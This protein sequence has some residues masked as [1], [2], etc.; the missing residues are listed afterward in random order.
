[1][2]PSRIVIFI[3]RDRAVAA[4]PCCVTKTAV[5]PIFTSAALLNYRITGENLV[6]EGVSVASD[7]L[8]RTPNLSNYYRRE[9]ELIRRLKEQLAARLIRVLERVS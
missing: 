2:R 7:Y 9:E 1:M 6:K 3:F 5:A 4:A 8:I